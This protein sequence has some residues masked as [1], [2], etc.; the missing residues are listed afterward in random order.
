MSYEGWQNSL[1]HSCVSIVIAFIDNG[2]SNL[3]CLA[4][5]QANLRRLKRGLKEV[6]YI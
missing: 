4:V 6:M 2:G 5:N 3:M 1:T